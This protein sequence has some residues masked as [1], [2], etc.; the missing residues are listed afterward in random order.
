MSEP[1][2]HSGGH[3]L[4]DHLQSVAAIAAGFSSTFEPSSVT[5][6]WAYLAGLWHDLGKYRPGFQR[7]LSQAD[8][9]DAHIEGKVGGREKT[10]SAAGALWAMRKLGEAHGPNGAL[11]A[12]VLAYLIA[13][14]HAGLYDWDG[15]LKERL[16]EADCQTE[17]AEAL[18]AHPPESILDHGDF[19]P[20][21]NQIPGGS[22]EI[23]RAHV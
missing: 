17:L 15:G 5:K 8:D 16:D 19:V 20:S 13:S 18:A 9:P 21:L 22:A 1:L 3:L 12:R 23:G 4:A 6:R 10:H 7:Y 14:H 11:A 2:A